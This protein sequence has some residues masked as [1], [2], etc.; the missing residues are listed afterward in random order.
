[1]LGSYLVKTVPEDVSLHGTWLTT[2]TIPNGHL[3]THRLDITKRDEVCALFEKCKPDIVIHC[4]AMGSVDY[5]QNHWQEAYVVNVKGTQNILD[6]A[7][8]NNTKVVFISTNAVY[9]GEHAPY[10]ADDHRSPVNIYG[11]MK[12]ESEVDIIE[13]FMGAFLVIR[14]IMLYGWAPHGARGNWATIVLDNITRGKEIMIVDDIITQPTYAWDCA[15][16]IWKLLE[17]DETGM[18]NIGGQDVMTLCDFAKIVAKKFYLNKDM[19][20]PIKSE[21]LENLAPRPRN[22][23]YCLDKLLEKGIMTLGVIDGLDA[24]KSESRL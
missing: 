12:A 3:Q 5:C 2:V 1:L 24:M 7:S 20:I 21:K 8:Y 15:S 13:E 23:T 6:M 16:V 22:T 10:K 4:A 19:V 17:L 18:Y 9:D 14:P 11:R